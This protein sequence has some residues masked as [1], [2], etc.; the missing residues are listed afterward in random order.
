W[1]GLRACVINAA[2]AFGRDLIG[3]AR[4]SGRRVVTYGAH[5]A[6]VVATS[7]D[8]T[9]PGIT[10]SVR[11]PRGGG[12]IRTSLTGAFNASNLLGVLGVLLASDI[13]LGAALEALANVTP[14]PG[15][16]ERVGGG[17]QPLIV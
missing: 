11:T 15:R 2:D 17:T 8:M 4:A 10:V 12:E 13:E 1:P 9:S 16:M 6:D 14:P 5:D 3:R 7:V